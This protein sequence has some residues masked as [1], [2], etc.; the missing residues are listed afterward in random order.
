MDKSRKNFETDNAV[1]D[2]MVNTLASAGDMGL[3]DAT[4]PD[5][6]ASLEE[7]EET[8]ELINPDANSMESRG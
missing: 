1:Q 3:I 2:I 6:P 4:A 5:S 7:V 8:T